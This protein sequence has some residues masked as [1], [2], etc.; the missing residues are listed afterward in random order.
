MSISQEHVVH[1]L[2]GYRDS[3]L[4]T[5]EAARV[6]RHL[7]DCPHCRAALEAQRADKA[8]LEPGWIGP[9]SWFFR[10]FWPAAAVVGLALLAAHGYFDSLKPTPYD[11]RVLGQSEWIPGSEAALHLR[12]ARPGVQGGVAGVPLTV[13]L[14][15]PGSGQS[16]RLAEVSTGP[17]GSAHPRFWL[18][19]WADSSYTLRVSSGPDGPG[20]RE[21]VTHKVKLQR[22]WRLMISTDKPVYQPGQTIKVRAL[23]LRRPDLRPVAGQDL[24]FS[25]TDPK[26][27]VVF[28]S[29][30][31]TSD[32]GI[33]ST[34]CALAAELL[35]GTC[36]VECRVGSISSAA[37]VDVKTYVLP[38]FKVAITFDR[39]YYLAGQ[40]VKGI[41]DA[42]YV[43]GKPVGG[44]TIELEASTPGA[45][46]RQ[47][48]PNVS[49]TSRADGTAEFSL[50]LPESLQGR[51]QEAGDASIAFTATV[52]DTA[53]QSQTRTAA[54]TVAS[55]PIRIELIP[56]AG[57]L[58]RGVQNRIHI[59]TSYPD[60][61]PAETRLAISGVDH[62]LR[63]DKQGAASFEF[64]EGTGTLNVIVRAIDA[65]GLVAGKSF[66]VVHGGPQDDFL[67][68][69][70]RAV[71]RGGQTLVLTALGTGQEPVFVD[72][73]KDGQTVLTESVPIQ[74][75]RGELKLELPAELSGTVLLCAYRYGAAGYAV[76]KTRVLYVLPA[77]D[78]KIKAEW[79]R[80]EYTPAATRGCP[81]H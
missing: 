48:Q 26:G 15:G 34:E 30:G 19:E 50:P 2:K 12:M 63:T 8:H 55:S 62:E 24:S 65:Q 68:R 10:I 57:V 38:K 17:D 77:R 6:E 78:L 36:R 16:V 70:D 42:R 39:P 74:M 51:P 67:V 14:N 61:R 73:I 27:N 53:G 76:R 75:G 59:L 40:V 32:H 1:L 35:E 21:I 33:G 11:L 29:R 66:P 43:F 20:G 28:R 79:D 18:P 81:W 80:T 49:P 56:E 69:T 72:L 5:D 54:V 3:T 52:K 37:T 25:V 13:E 22:S 58:A 41:V 71:Y 23:A 4:R 47:F 9:L 64:A 46:G 44:G 60:G 31:V 7:G 45:L